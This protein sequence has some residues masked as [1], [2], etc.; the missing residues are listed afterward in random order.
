MRALLPGKPNISINKVPTGL[1]S[2]VGLAAICYHYSR[3]L[4][5]A[6]GGVSRSLY[7]SFNQVPSLPVPQFALIEQHCLPRLLGAQLGLN[8]VTMGLASGLT[9]AFNHSNLSHP[10]AADRPVISAPF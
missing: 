2:I 6:S 4:A 3:R 7:D 5:A 1:A 9:G 8:S 10:L